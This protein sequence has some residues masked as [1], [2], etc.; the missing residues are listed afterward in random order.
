MSPE[1]MVSYQ[2]GDTPIADLLDQEVGLRGMAVIRDQRSFVRG[3]RLGVSMGHAVD[4]CDGFLT[5]LTPNSLYLDAAPDAPRPVLDDELR[6]AMR[7][8]AEYELSL[9]DERTF[10]PEAVRPVVYPVCVGLGNNREEVAEQVRA[11]TGLD[12]S[13]MWTTSPFPTPEHF[14]QEAAATVAAELLHLLT[15]CADEPV[16]VTV[17]TRGN[18]VPIDA[19]LVINA[20]DLLGG[21]ARRPGSPETWVRILAALQDVESTLSAK[22][23]SRQI[24]LAPQCHLT[25]AIAAGRIFNQTGRWELAV[26]GRHGTTTRPPTSD[27][28]PARIHWDEGTRTSRTATVEIDLLGHRITATVD[29]QLPDWTT[30]PRGRLTVTRN[31]T[32]DLDPEQ[33]AAVTR[34]IAER[35]RTAVSDHKLSELHLFITAPADVAVL[36]GHQLSGMDVDL[37]LYEY[38]GHQYRRTLLLPG[39]LP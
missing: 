6:P 34:H 20:I 16:R 3:Q 29:E 30:G 14:D 25:A 15:P 28:S 18:S 17:A 21:H 13:S 7:R 35:V 39:S 12:L 37:Q 36:L 38:D 26:S 24:V 31:V 33:T 23:L 4:T 19:D 27:G 10:T 8:R 1:V 2:V 9:R 32:D 22:L 11:Q 5:V